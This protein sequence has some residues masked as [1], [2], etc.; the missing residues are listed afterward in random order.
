MSTSHYLLSK[1]Y[2]TSKNQP[3]IKVN[4][5][6][7]VHSDKK[8]RSMWRMGVVTEL[9]KGKMDN[10]I[11]GALVRLS[12]NSLLSTQLTNYTRLSMC[13]VID[14]NQRTLGI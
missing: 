8:P 1:H 13:E 9:I 12:N 5:V 14:Q 4:D 6:V 7:L 10:N 11:R 3:F 2:S